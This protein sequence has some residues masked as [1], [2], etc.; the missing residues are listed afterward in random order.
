VIASGSN[1]ATLAVDLAL[2]ASWVVRM[3]PRLLA[4]LFSLCCLFLAGCSPARFLGAMATDADQARAAHY[5]ELLQ[6]GQ[7]RGIEADLDPSLPKSGVHEALVKMSLG[8]PRGAP[9]SR[10]LVG[11]NFTKSS[12]ANDVNLTYEYEFPGKWLLVNVVMRHGADRTTIVGLHMNFIPDSL[13]QANRF[14]LLGKSPRH[15]LVL[16]LA[17]LAPL[18]SIYALIRC[19]RLKLRRRRWIWFLFILFGFGTVSLNWTTGQCTFNPISFELLSTSAS[20]PFYGPWTLSV[21]IPVGAIV[22]LLLQ[23]RLAASAALAERPVG[24]R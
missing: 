24:R 3:R 7:L 23:K 2:R 15:Y 13:E 5:A 6:S 21:A 9:A 16:A 12:T 4:G 1:A 20:R 11:V 19:V 14:N 17:V 22:F 18:L 8:F 10:K